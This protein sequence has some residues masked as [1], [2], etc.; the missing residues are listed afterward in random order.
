MAS[1]KRGARVLAIQRSRD[2]GALVRVTRASVR[3]LAQPARPRECEQ[4]LEGSGKQSLS[5]QKE[6]QVGEAGVFP[7]DR[8]QD[9]ASCSSCLP[10]RQRLPVSGIFPR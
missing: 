1:G 3:V 9:R 8:R 2:R 10:R 7:T 6:R 4:S 5:V